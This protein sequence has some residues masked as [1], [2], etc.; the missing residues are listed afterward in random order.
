MG[1]AVDGFGAW[2]SGP[3]LDEAD[4]EA[5]QC[6]CTIKGREKG[7]NDLHKRTTVD[8]YRPFLSLRTSF[9]IPLTCPLGWSSGIEILLK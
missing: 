2:L 3:G 9:D 5:E 1:A 7:I 6:K 8:Y 4:G